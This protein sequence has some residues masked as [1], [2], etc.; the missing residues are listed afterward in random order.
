V[1]AQ[2]VEHLTIDGEFGGGGLIPAAADGAMTTSIMT[3]SITI[4]NII[5]L[6]GTQYNLA[7]QYSGKDT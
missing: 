1:R 3:L 6:S 7:E 2:L 4:L 5:T